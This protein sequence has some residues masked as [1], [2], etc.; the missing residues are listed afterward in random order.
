MTVLA[1]ANPVSGSGKA[2]QLLTELISKAPLKIV[3][4]LYPSAIQSSKML[5]REIQSKGVTDVVAI[6]GDGLVHLCLQEI[7]QTRIKFHVIPAGTG[8]DFATSTGRSKNDISRTISEISNGSIS[9][10]DLGLITHSSGQR[11]FGQV[12]STGFDAIVNERAN[13]MRFIKGQMKYNIATLL[14]LF[15]FKPI[16][17]RLEIDGEERTLDAM[18][19]SVA[20][21]PSYGGGMLICPMANRYDGFLDVIIIKPVSKFELLRVFPKVFSGSHVTH[22]KIEFLRVK[23]ISIEADTVAFADGEY[24]S[25]LPIIV[26]AVSDALAMAN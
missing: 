17:Y 18:L 5:R 3:P 16:R 19:V 22:P 14:V 10:S 25:Q 26:A 24:I 2:T 9:M 8:N 21:G 13:R 1:V 15:R 6:G 7:A 4:I 23:N 11:W 20:N 12:L